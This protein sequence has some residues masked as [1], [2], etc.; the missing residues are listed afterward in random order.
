MKKSL[1]LFVFFVSLT[2]NAQTL[3]KFK[4]ID[5]ATKEIIPFANILFSKTNFKGTSS[6]IDGVFLHSV[7]S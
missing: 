5:S 7:S 2:M 1:V 6:D 3:K 4:L